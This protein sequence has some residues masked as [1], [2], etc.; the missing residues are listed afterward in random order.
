[1]FTKIVVD[2]DKDQARHL[3]SYLN[4]INPEH[5]TVDATDLFPDGFE[6]Y[7]DPDNNFLKDALG[8]KVPQLKDLTSISIIRLASSFTVTFLSELLGHLNEFVASDEDEFTMKGLK[9]IT[10]LYLLCYCNLIISQLNDLSN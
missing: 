10:V 1:M 4:S 5:Q 7:V 3:I 6:D 9:N 8:D 2:L